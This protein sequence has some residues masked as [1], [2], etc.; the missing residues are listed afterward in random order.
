M[1]PILA[2]LIL[3]AYGIHR[4]YIYIGLLAMAYAVLAIFAIV[5]SPETSDVDLEG[6]APRPLGMFPE[7]G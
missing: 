4:A 1:I 7:R 2:G 6:E 3:R 5:A